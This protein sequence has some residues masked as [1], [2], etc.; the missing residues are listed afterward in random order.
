MEALNDVVRAGKARYIGA[1]SMYAWQFM[2]ALMVSRLNG[3]AEFVSMQNHLNLINREEEREMLPLCRDQGDR[4]HSG[5]APACARALRRGRG[6]RPAS[7]S[8]KRSAFGKTLYT[9]AQES[10]RAVVDTVGRIADGRG[11]RG[12]QGR[13]GL[14]DQQPGRS[15]R[16]SSARPGRKPPDRRG[17]RRS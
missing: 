16:P 9:A 11:C 3:W 1:S 5:G 8:G 4:R 13:P 17:S 10:D 2:K 15:P 14:G 12:R 6:M 7:A